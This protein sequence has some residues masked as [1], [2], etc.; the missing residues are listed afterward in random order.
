MKKTVKLMVV[1]LSVILMLC[2]CGNEETAKPKPSDNSSVT[3]G[4]TD[5]S[6]TDNFSDVGDDETLDLDF[7]DDFD[8]DFDDDFGGSG[9]YNDDESEDEQEDAEEEEEEYVIPPF[10][11]EYEDT[12]I[13]DP[14]KKLTPSEMMKKCIDDGLKVKETVIDIGLSKPVKL[15]RI[16]DSHLVYVNGADNA[17]AREQASIRYQYYVDADKKLERCVN[18]ANALGVD[19]VTFTGDIW[20]FFSMGNLAKFKKATS[21]LDDF[22][23]SLGNHED[24]RKVGGNLTIGDELQ[25]LRKT[26]SKYVKNDLSFAT[27]KVGEITVV[28]MDNSRY[29]FSENQVEKMKAEIAKGRPILIMMHTPLYTEKLLETA[30]ANNDAG[31]LM[32]YPDSVATSGGYRKMD[33]ATKEMVDLIN[34]NPDIIKGIFAGHLHYDHESNLESGIPQYL[35]RASVQEKG[36]IEI[37]EVK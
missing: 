20:D 32:G 6:V 7:D 1:I 14:V 27:R 30:K 12:G 10:V 23:F 34:A 15:A 16:T 17:I 33:S 21:V 2:S 4:D 26:I 25:L 18:Y 35:L 37:I 8:S 11:Q 9:N 19:L 5:S 28:S 36:F 24:I 3:S 22:L 29:T 31:S 13:H